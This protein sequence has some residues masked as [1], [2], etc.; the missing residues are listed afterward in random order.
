[1][2]TN[3]EKALELLNLGTEKYDPHNT[4]IAARYFSQALLHDPT[5]GAAASSLAAIL[6]GAGLHEPALQYAKTAVEFW[7]EGQIAWNHLII[8]VNKARNSIEDDQVR[9]RID[10]EIRD[11]QDRE[12]IKR[13]NA[14]VQ[15]QPGDVLIRAMPEKEFIDSLCESGE[16]FFRASRYFRKLDESDPRRDADENKPI[17][18]VLVPEGTQHKLSNERLERK[19]D[20]GGVVMGHSFKGGG[21]GVIAGSVL[22]IGGMQNLYCFTVVSEPNIDQF[23]KNYKWSELGDHA[24]AIKDIPAFN[25]RVQHTLATKEKGGAARGHVTYV[26]DLAIDRFFGAIFSPFIKRMEHDWQFEYRYSYHGDG[27]ESELI[28]VGSLTDIAETFE[29]D[30]LREWL[31]KRFSNRSA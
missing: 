9:L 8:A 14:I 15:L 13:R 2:T 24:I 10:S 26:D 27:S 18:E 1:M 6:I 22:E 28:E 3:P 20:S 4:L 23:M 21:E 29:I 17:E 11:Y 5:L 25:D 7:P 19:I 16:M 30:E 12:F 31:V